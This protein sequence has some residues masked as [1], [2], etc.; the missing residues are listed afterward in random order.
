MRTSQTAGVFF[1][2]YDFVV[3]PR[4]NPAQI[5]LRFDGARKPSVDQNGN[6]IL[7]TKLGEI[8]HQAPVARRLGRK[9]ITDPGSD[10][11]I[12]PLTQTN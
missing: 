3:A 7:K 5:K 12:N 4:G 8:I 9:T 1:L 6:L 2:E 10:L 11:S